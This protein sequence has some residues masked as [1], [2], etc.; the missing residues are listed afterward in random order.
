MKKHENKLRRLMWTSAFALALPVLALTGC[1]GGKYEKIGVSAQESAETSENGAEN[2][3]SNVEIS[4]LAA[5]RTTQ[6]APAMEERNETVYVVAIDLNVRRQP[7]MDSEVVTVLQMGDSLLRVGYAESW[8]RVLYQN[9]ECYVASRY[10]SFDPP[11][12]PE[13]VRAEETAAAVL[14]DRTEIGLN[15]EICRFCKD[16]VR[17]GIAVP[18]TGI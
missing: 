9:Q 4:S 3:D 11:V 14:A 13:T 12:I 17:K 16:Y 1:G 15:P 6:T 8:S 10:L 18:F 2:R 5:E 7:S